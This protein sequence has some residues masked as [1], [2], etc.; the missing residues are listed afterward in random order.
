MRLKDLRNDSRLWESSA[1]EEEE[2][3]VEGWARYISGREVVA[4]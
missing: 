1:F 2:G 3:R 4:Y